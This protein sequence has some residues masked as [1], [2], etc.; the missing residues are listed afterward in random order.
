MNA[1]ERSASFLLD[2]DAGEVKCVYTPDT[3]V[4]KYAQFFATVVTVM[5]MVLVFARNAIAV[6]QFTHYFVSC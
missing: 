1:P 6:L 4:R 5:V 2:E 3:K